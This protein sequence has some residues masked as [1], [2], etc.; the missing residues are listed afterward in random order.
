[1]ANRPAPALVLRD[2]DREELDRW[3]RSRSV[4]A[5]LARRAR[6]V[7]LAADGVGNR[8]IARLVAASP[9]TV[10]AWRER[11]Q[12]RGMVGLNDRERPGRPRTLDHRSIVAETLKPPPKKLGVTH[13][14]S[15]LLADR[16]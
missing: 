9:T 14:S 4:S 7:L 15:R 1:M 13:W 12:A 10:I 11:Y 8:E 5:G 6:M 3:V 16:L 2:G